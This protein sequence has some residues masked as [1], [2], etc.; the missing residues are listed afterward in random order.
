MSGHKEYPSHPSQHGVT[1]EDY[2]E[3]YDRQQQH[4]HEQQYA[5]QQQYRQAQT[6]TPNPESV[7]SGDYDHT[8]TQPDSEEFY[9]KH[10]EDHYEQPRELSGSPSNTFR[11]TPEPMSPHYRQHQQLEQQEKQEQTPMT[12]GKRFRLHILRT[13]TVPRLRLLWACL[14]VFGTMS[15]LAIMPAYAFRNIFE[16]AHFSNPTYTFFLV[17]TVGTSIAAIWQSLCPF[18]IRQS[19]RA[20]LPRIINHPITQTTTIII[21]VILTILNFFSWIILASNSYGAKTNCHEGPLSNKGGYVTQCRGVNTAIV[22]NVIVFLLWIPIALVIVCG[23]MERGLWWWGEDDG[24]AQGNEAAISR[25]PNMM[26]EEEF[27]LKIGMRG[28]QARGT[29][30]DQEQAS[31]IDPE[32]QYH[33]DMVQQPKP[34]YITPIASQ[35]R[36]PSDAHMGLEDEES[37]DNAASPTQL[38]QW[39]YAS[40]P[41]IA[42]NLWT[43]QAL[44]SS[45]CRTVSAPRGAFKAG[46]GDVTGCRT[47]R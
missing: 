41:T 8:A 13:A 17:A 44:S 5:Q 26:S 30:G 14:A 1:A 36:Q 33:D 15:W 25:G 6:G 9:Y 38:E 46:F 19:Q 28:K 18:L 29:R 39:T 3:N 24:W 27:D 20:I 40:S 35:F 4:Q 21:S 47:G 45:L 16:P 32:S 12:R 22:L 34:A 2:V 11:D 7:Y 43:I 23:T 10:Q 31:Q 37:F 42:R